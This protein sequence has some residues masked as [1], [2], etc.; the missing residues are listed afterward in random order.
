MKNTFLASTLFTVI[1]TACTTN[2]SNPVRILNIAETQADNMLEKAREESAIPRSVD[3]EGNINWIKG[4]SDWTEGFWPGICWY[5]YQNNKED[6]WKEAAIEFQEM[7]SEHRFDSST[8]D[9]GFMFNNSFGKAYRITGEE[10]YKKIL[11]DAANSL[12][13]R[14]NP[15][16]G[17]IKSWDWAPDRWQFPVI[18]DNMMNLEMLFEASL[19]S[20]NDYYKEIAIS[21]ADTTRI[22]HFRNDYSTWHII[23]YD[24]RTGRVIQKQTQ[25][26]FA[27]SSAWTRGQAWGLYGYTIAYRYTRN[28]I[29]LNQAIQIADYNLQR[30]PKDMITP[31]DYDAPDS[32]LIYKD[33]SA[34][35]IL[36]SALIELSFY[37]EKPEY[38]DAAKK[39]IKILTSEN[40]LAV[41]GTNNYFVL[42][43]SVGSFPENSEVDVPIIYADYY[44]IEALLRLKSIRDRD[45]FDYRLVK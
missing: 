35:A 41:P 10:K 36:A 21:H 24:P 43:H 14:F 28:N 17:C 15:K 2:K 39:I 9:L 42:K 3:K 37:A 30:L 20:G 16:V 31:W 23:D 19:I 34:T 27:D 29:Y 6:I 32:I 40:Y 13:S 38:L 45:L 26:G 33:V 44:F 18:I 4:W 5:F 22:N 12:A 1:L 25:Q 8:H 7:I 11:L